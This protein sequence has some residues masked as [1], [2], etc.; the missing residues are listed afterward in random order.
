VDAEAEGVAGLALL[1]MHA[2]GVLAPQEDEALRAR[3][4]QHP[5][6]SHTGEEGLGRVLA[7][8]EARA[9]AL[10]PERFF[11]ECLAAVRPALR[12]TAYRIAAEIALADG[13]VVPEEVEY[14]AALRKGLSLSREDAAAVHKAL[15][16]RG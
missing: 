3:L 9:L 1:A 6:F 11:A 5:F 10:G 15:A 14:L 7:K 8:V 2:D 12:L 4:L 16:R 13:H